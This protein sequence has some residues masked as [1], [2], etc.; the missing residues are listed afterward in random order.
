MPIPRYLVH[1]TPGH[2]YDTSGPCILV[3]RAERAN[4]FF[5]PPSCF[6][7]APETDKPG[8]LVEG[9]DVDN[10]DLEGPGMEL[11]AAELGVG[12]EE[13]GDEMNP[14]DVAAAGNRVR[15]LV[16]CVYF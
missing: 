3:V 2:P 5:F 7:P 12:V 6:V 1:H 16:C 15:L 8:G 14:Q 11:D 9:G 4:H 10:F 13:Y